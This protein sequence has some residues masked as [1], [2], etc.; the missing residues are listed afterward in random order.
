MK[1]ISK[2]KLLSSILIIFLIAAV[3]TVTA[4]GA[5]T[6]TATETETATDTAT[7]TETATETATAE[8][9]TG[10]EDGTAGDTT[11]TVTQYVVT[12]VTDEH[13]VVTVYDTQD[14]T[15]EGTETLTA[16]A[17]NGETGAITTDGTGQVNFVLTFDDGYEI[18]SMEDEPSGNRKNV[19]VDP[20]GDGS[21]NYYR[22]TKITGDLTVTIES[23]ATEEVEDLTQGYQ[24]SFVTDEHVTVTVYKTQD[25]AADGE[26]T[27]VAYSRDSATGLLTKSDGQVNFVV[28]ADDGYE[29]ASVDV[30]GQYKNLKNDPEADGSTD[31]YRITKIAGDLTVTI[32]TQNK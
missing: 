10:T 20:E 26:T 15:G 23:K 31:Y 24:V 8:T 14:I 32:T 18:A 21:E 25:L 5:L 7:A 29:I 6:T 28:N 4:C 13:V 19:K 27:D 30:D 1:T 11:E 3:F 17:R 9:A 2:Q 16:Y 12:F 22:I